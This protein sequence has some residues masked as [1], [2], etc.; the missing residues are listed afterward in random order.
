MTRPRKKS[1]TE[2]Q[3]AAD[4]ARRRRLESALADPLPEGTRDESDEAWGDRSDRSDDEWFRKQVPPHH[5]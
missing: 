3:A 5:G 4:A 2:Q 1:E